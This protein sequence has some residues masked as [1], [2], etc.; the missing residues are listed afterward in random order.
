MLLVDTE[1][2]RDEWVQRLDQVC[3][4]AAA[5]TAT[6]T[7]Q[8]IGVAA[9]AG[10]GTDRW[11]EPGLDGW[12]RVKGASPDSRNPNHA[13]SPGDRGSPSEGKMALGG[14]PVKSLFPHTNATSPDSPPLPPISEEVAANIELAMLHLQAKY[15][16]GGEGGDIHRG[17]DGVTPD[18]IDHAIKNQGSK[19]G[20]EVEGLYR[21][22]GSSEDVAS[23]TKLLLGTSANDEEKKSSSDSS[24][25]NGLASIAEA[26]EEQYLRQRLDEATP[27]AIACGIKRCLARHFAPLTGYDGFE[28]L[29]HVASSGSMRLLHTSL[30][31]LPATSQRLLKTVTAHLAAVAA[32]QAVTRMAVGALATVFAPTLL[33]PSERIDDAM[34]VSGDQS[35]FVY[36]LFANGTSLTICVSLF[37]IN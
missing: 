15:L 12:S 7:E 16:C 20:A 19:R 18:M 37:D 27:H 14:V 25:S 26:L 33:R 5:T 22:S 6:P 32:Q 2:A 13:S 30:L 11:L 36:L 17:G 1:E 21:I 9:A 8:K 34:Q 4:S 28:D 23:I 29:V 31:L 24:N 10:G 35:I 3:T